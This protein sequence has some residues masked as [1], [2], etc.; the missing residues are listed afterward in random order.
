MTFRP[1]LL[2]RAYQLA[3]SGHCKTLTQIKLA[4]H[5]EGFTAMQINTNLQGSSVTSGLLRRCKGS[6]ALIGE[7]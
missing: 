1:T 4:L 6:R 7:T 2:E 5:S 3:E